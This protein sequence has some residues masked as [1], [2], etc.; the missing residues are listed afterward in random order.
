MKLHILSDLHL[1]FSD[2]KAPDVGANVIV[3]AGDISL[4][5]RGLPLR[6]NSCR[7]YKTRTWGGDEGSEWQGTQRNSKAER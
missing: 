5:T 2:F 1:E 7:L 3:L 4:H 6:Q